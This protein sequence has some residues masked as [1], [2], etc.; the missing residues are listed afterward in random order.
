MPDEPLE[1][2]VTVTVPPQVAV[3]ITIPVVAVNPT[4]GTPGV[5]GP[6]GGDLF[7]T[8]H[9]SLPSATWVVTIPSAFI[10]AGKIPDVTVYDTGGSKID[11]FGTAY[12]ATAHTLTLYFSAPFAGTVYLN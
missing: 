10:T 12:D 6:S 3:A 8:I 9:Q 1:V 2:A 11:L 7:A 4:I 5:P